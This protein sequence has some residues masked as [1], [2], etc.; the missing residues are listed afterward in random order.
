MRTALAVMAAFLLC[1]PAVSHARDAG[2][3][4]EGVAKALGAETL[5]HIAGNAH[6]D[7]LLVHW[8]KERRLSG[9]DVVPIADLHTAVGHGH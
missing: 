5:H 2:A 3:T 7:G 8:S 1:L 9:A 6:A 4:L